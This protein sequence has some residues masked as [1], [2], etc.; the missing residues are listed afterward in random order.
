QCAE[1]LV[2]GA[3]GDAPVVGEVDRVSE[4]RATFV[5]DPFD[6]DP[7]RKHRQTWSTFL[8]GRN[9]V[10]NRSSVSVPG[11]VDSLPGAL[12]RRSG[13]RSPPWPCPSPD[14]RSYRWSGRRTR[15]PNSYMASAARSRNQPTIS[16]GVTSCKAEQNAAST[17]PV[18]RPAA[19]LIAFLTF[20]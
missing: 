12:V 20:E 15:A 14:R 18:V 5:P 11:P 9:W 10:G 19:D 4:I 17:A 2:V 13:S 8:R 6:R 1:G 7:L 16:S 3:G